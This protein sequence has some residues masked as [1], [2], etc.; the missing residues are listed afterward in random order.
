MTTYAPGASVAD[1]WQL[2]AGSVAVQSVTPP[3]LKV[4]VPSTPPGRPVTESV[5]WSPYATVG[6]EANSAIDDAT[7]VIE[8][9]APVALPALWLPSPE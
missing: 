3:A 9:L 1:V 6:S 5:S 2:V 4:I 7:R 8:K